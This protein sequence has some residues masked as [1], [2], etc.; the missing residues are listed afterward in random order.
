MS[1]TQDDDQD[2]STIIIE[3]SDGGNELNRRGGS[4]VSIGKIILFVAIGLGVLGG[5]ATGAYFYVKSNLNF[6]GGS[7]Q[8][9]KNRRSYAIAPDGIGSYE[10]PDLPEVAP[11][12]EAPKQEEKNEIAPP[13]IIIERPPPSSAVQQV[14]GEGM[15][16]SLTERRLS[17]GIKVIGGGREKKAERIPSRQVKVMKN[18]DYTLVKGAKIPCTLETNIVS[19]QHGFTSCIVQQDV[20]SA[21]ARLLL[22][23]KGSRVTGEYRRDVRNGDRRLEIIWDR[24]ITPYNVV[25]QL[26]SPSTDALGASGV[27]GEVDN[28]WMLR[29]G[30]ALLVSTFSDVLNIAAE[31][32]QNAEVIVGTETAKTSQNMAEK[33]LE[34]NIDL[35][36]IIYI[37][38]GEVINIFVADDIDLSAVY[39]ASN[40]K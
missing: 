33:I 40:V 22:I 23:E 4:S 18:I 7:Q 30:S 39:S 24:L 31:N 19:E 8:E 29:I 38:N 26:Q 34:K 1:S 35:S 2:N 12:V 37:R 5:I 11:V 36:P 10:P 13:E 14:S 15:P 3:D 17:S 16:P 28:R 9:F 21:N 32:S 6:G 25:V 20:Y 27:T